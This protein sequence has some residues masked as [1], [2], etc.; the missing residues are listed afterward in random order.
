MKWL[1]RL[2]H[3]LTFLL[4]TI[5]LV[6]IFFLST[7][8]G[9]QILMAIALPHVPGLTIEQVQGE[10]LK[11]IQLTK[12]HYHDSDMDVYIDHA[13]LIWRPQ[14][15]LRKKQFKIK[16]LNIQGIRVIMHAKTANQQAMIWPKLPVTIILQ[17]AIIKDL[18]LVDEQQ[19]I[20]LQELQGAL[21]LTPENQFKIHIAW[22]KLQ[23]LEELQKMSSSEGQITTQGTWPA[24]ELQIN[25]HIEAAP[26][27]ELAINGSIEGHFAAM[28]Q[29]R[30]EVH[31]PEEGQLA[32][33]GFM[34][35]STPISWQLK[36]TGNKINPVI[37]WP[38][39]PAI[40]KNQYEVRATSQGVWDKNKQD[41]ILS[42]AQLDSQKSTVMPIALAG[43]M[44][45][46]SLSSRGLTAGPSPQKNE[47]IIPQF[48]AQIGATHLAITASAAL[49]PLWQIRAQVLA[50]DLSA[51][52]I[53]ITKWQGELT[54]DSET[55]HLT[56]ELTTDQGRLSL[57]LTG[58]WLKNHWQGKLNQ[59]ALQQTPLGTWQLTHPIALLL[60]TAHVA[61]APFCLGN[62]N[63][64]LCGNTSWTLN[65]GVSGRLT[66][67]DFSLQPLLEQFK[68]P[69]ILNSIL[70]FL[71][72][73]DIPSKGLPQLQLSMH[74]T[75]GSI[76]FPT[77]AKPM[78]QSQ[79][80]DPLPVIAF[81][82][83]DLT[84]H[85]D[86]GLWVKSVLQI[87]NAPLRAEIAW[88]TFNKESKPLQQLPFSASLAWRFEQWQQIQSLY[89][90][91]F[92]LS[93]GLLNIDLN[94]RG[95]LLAPQITGGMSFTQGQLTVPKYL[96]NIQHI[97]AE[98]M[99]NGY[100]QLKLSGRAQSG[101][102][103]LSLQGVAHLAQLQT[104]FSLQGQNFQISN[105]PEY[106]IT[107]SPTLNVRIAP[108]A[109]HVTGT[110]VVPTAKIA[111]TN[112]SSTEELSPDVV[113][114]HTLESNQPTW[115]MFSSITMQAG[116]DVNLAVKGVTGKIAG[117]LSVTTS[118]DTEPSA[119]GTL[120]IQKGT[121]VA[122]GQTLT[123]S[124]GRFI[125]T[126]GSLYN[127][128]LSIE[129][130]RQLDIVNS[131]PTA[132]TIGQISSWNP[133]EGQKLTVGIRIQ[134]SLKQP[135]ISLFSEPMALSQANILSYLILGR[136]TNQITSSQSRSLMGAATAL[137]IAGKEFSQITQQLQQT[138]HIDIGVR[139]TSQLDTKTGTVTENTALVLG[140][141][142]SSRLFLNY[143]IGLIQALNTLKVRYLLSR[144]WSLQT[145]SSTQ[146]NG[147]DVLYNYAW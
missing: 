136:P 108:E 129:A 125:Y 130:I 146:A 110:V 70:S 97:N 61:I 85:V 74:L 2:A 53:K 56:T 28:Q 62:G 118:P 17:H 51:G 29:V 132:N 134:G 4:M 84:A 3:G 27:P 24:Y 19:K 52:G 15:L 36:L 119:V 21:Q 83:G 112:F 69:V 120:D 122:Y 117:Q 5:V 103:Q 32:L 76:K 38:G 135:K 126:G 34:N 137:Q 91:W 14:A 102:G 131:M 57:H 49:T 23:R 44:I 128:G 121:Y 47:L 81:Q 139:S 106:Q 58:H 93:H 87:M 25:T 59:F 68:S 99:A 140:K 13:Q 66:L 22:Q 145:E 16:N 98:V 33:A 124:K 101:T 133:T 141:A 100:D 18:A 123:M 88:P 60:S 43:K 80:T 114:T 113:F 6:I 96:L 138:F 89:D 54:G 12:L 48:T 92:H 20:T 35:L 72:N 41:I 90:Q 115:K 79:Q 94:A 71:L 78:P 63:S 1:T 109:I 86:D 37:F 82:G 75:P 127:P 26:F 116:S 105:T 147:M 111:P 142:L 30:F 31:S 39:F 50:H 65:K 46:R 55:H 95:T 107:V 40:L 143:S 77:K 11:S 45:W 7:T 8:P 73:W 104:N 42:L 67:K 9:L 64:A 10:L 144:H